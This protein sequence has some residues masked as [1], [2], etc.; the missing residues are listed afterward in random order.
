MQTQYQTQSQPRSQSF[1]GFVDKYK[2]EVVNKKS[3]VPIIHKDIH[4]DTPTM[5]KY[6]IKSRIVPN[7]VP[8][9]V[10][11]PSVS[12]TIPAV[13]TMS[14]RTTNDVILLNT[15]TNNNILL[16]LSTLI[17]VFL[18]II[19]IIMKVMNY[20]IGLELKKTKTFGVTAI[21][22]VFL[23]PF[24]A[25]SVAEAFSNTLPYQG[26][27]S[28]S[29]GAVNASTAMRFR[30]Y[31]IETGGTAVWDSGERSIQVTNG[32]F[33]V[34]LGSVVPFGSAIDFNTNQYYIEVTIEG[35]TL[36]PREKLSAV[37]YA[38]TTAGVQSLASAPTASNAGGLY[39]NTSS[40]TLSASNGTDWNDVLT[41]SANATTTIKGNAQVDGYQVVTGDLT[42]NGSTNI[43]TTTIGGDLHTTGTVRFSHFGAGQV[44]LTATGELTVSSDERLKN[45]EANGFNRG[46]EALTN[47][48]PI[49]YKWNEISGLEQEHTYA[50]F[51]A[52]NIQANIPEAVGVDGRGFLTLS[53]RPILAAVV[54]AIKEIWNKFTSFD[55]RLDT[56]ES[57]IKALKAAQNQ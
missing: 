7:T 37:A 2:N 20:F 55:N 10:Y 4:T 1:F 15:N 14:N 23:I 41:T 53:D 8:T 30:L 32:A 19:Y 54:N 42:V 17:A 52:Q 57:E 50:G 33:S 24:L 39:Y 28:N 6:K 45:I 34:E 44:S 36:S 46:I 11:V 13:K 51:S 35:N 21:F 26:Y 29:A 31:T 22:L 49:R 5:Q 18:S 9:N 25:S 40:N 3:E 56:I 27:I 47:I 12:Q 38:H 43:A 48:K 16:K